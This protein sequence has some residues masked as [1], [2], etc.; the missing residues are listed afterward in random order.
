MDITIHKLS[1]CVAE[2][3]EEERRFHEAI[4]WYKKC[5]EMCEEGLFHLEDD[6]YDRLNTSLVNLGLAQKK[7]GLLE[8]ALASYV[9]GGRCGVGG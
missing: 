8:E 4:S 1:M 3:L 7:A 2:R 5:V 9:G 6:P